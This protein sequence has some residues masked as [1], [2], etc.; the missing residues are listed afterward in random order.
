MTAGGRLGSPAVDAEVAS[1]QKLVLC[2]DQDAEWRAVLKEVL[3]AYRLVFADEAFDALRETNRGRFHA[4]ILD[5]WLPGSSGPALCRDIRKADPHAPIVFCSSAAR[6]ECVN[7]AMA[8]GASAYILKSEVS[9]ELALKLRSLLALADLRSLQANVAEDAAIQDELER[10]VAQS[11][12]RGVAAS[13]RSKQAIER[14]VRI[15]AQKAFIEAHGTLADFEKWWPH[16]YAR[17][18]ESDDDSEL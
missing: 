8:A 5:Y 9:A 16:L 3:P 13:E 14:T 2:V 11:R 1:P 17:A 10:R 18:R 12:E 7:S 15:R 6:D 4:Y